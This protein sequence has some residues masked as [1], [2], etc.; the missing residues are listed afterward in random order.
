[1]KRLCIFTTSWRATD[2]IIIIIIIIIIGLR[3]LNSQQLRGELMIRYDTIRYF[4]DN[5][6]FIVAIV[7]AYFHEK[8]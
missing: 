5:L 2:F 3:M 7:Y 1:M 8:Q 6:D 4:T